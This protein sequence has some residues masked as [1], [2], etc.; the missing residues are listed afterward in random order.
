MFSLRC[1]RPKIASEKGY[2]CWLPRRPGVV[3]PIEPRPA[4]LLRLKRWRHRDERVDVIQDG[5]HPSQR[6]CGLA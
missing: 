2:L 3:A 1:N 4:K 5:G 6:L